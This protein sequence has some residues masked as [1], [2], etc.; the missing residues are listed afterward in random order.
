[1]KRLSFSEMPCDRCGS[2]R[3][4]AKVWK[5]TV[6]TLTGKTTIEYSQII[7]VNVE[8]QK[9]FDENLAKEVKKREVLRLEKEKRDTIRKTNS[10]HRS[11][12]SHK[13]H[14]RI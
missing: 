5:E 14:S 6:P 7:C 13:N 4:V 2:K 10:L 11:S 9:A 1:M 3:K 12:A 8:C